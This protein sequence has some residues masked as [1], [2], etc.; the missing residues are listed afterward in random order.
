MQ[1]IFLLYIFVFGG[2]AVIREF[3][4]IKEWTV[5]G[6]DLFGAFLLIILCILTVFFLFKNYSRF[7]QTRNYFTFI[8]SFTG[9]LFLGLIFGH[10]IIR[11]SYDNSKT[12]FEA[13]NET[14]GN[15]E[16][17]TLDFKMNK[18]LKGQRVDRF[19]TTSYWGSYTKQGDTLI[20]DIP[21][22]FKMGRHAILQGNILQFTDDTIHFNVYKH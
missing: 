11:S 22:D 15:D 19:G 6:G 16:G 14:T 9:L 3:Q 12:L 1:G 17:F 10:M 20:L 13:Y 2:I 8:H 18:H 21:L 5:F 7:K 4:N